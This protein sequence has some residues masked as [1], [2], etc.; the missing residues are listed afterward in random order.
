MSKVIQ[1]QTVPEEQLGRHD[2]PSM[3]E[4]MD[5][6]EVI[7]KEVE[8]ANAMSEPV[9]ENIEGQISQEKDTETCHTHQ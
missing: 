2:K 8:T 9:A 5:E 1:D 6:G 4:P 7:D 3:L